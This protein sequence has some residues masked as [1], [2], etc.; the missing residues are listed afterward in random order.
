LGSAEMNTV[1][2]QILSHGN[3]DVIFFD[4]PPTLVVSDS[5]ILASST[6]AQTVLVVESGRTNRAAAVRAVQQ[7]N[8]LSLPL[9][10]AILNR[11]DPRDVDAG[12]GTYYYGYSRYLEPTTPK[13]LTEKMD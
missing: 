4:T 12:Y 9:L 3:Y 11:L 7:I 8:D 13:E 6:G 10:G 1:M 2:Q 5:N